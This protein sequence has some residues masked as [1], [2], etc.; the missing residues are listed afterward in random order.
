[1]TS[2][3]YV[4]NETPTSHAQFARHAL[5][6]ARGLRPW[7][8]KTVA[9]WADNSPDFVINLFALW[10]VDAVPL[11]LSR[12]LPWT[13][14]VSLLEAAG[15][16]AVLTHEPGR[17]VPSPVSVL[18][19]ACGRDGEAEESGSEAPA[20]PTIGSK[21]Q[22]VAVILHTSGTTHLPKLVPVTRANLHASLRLEEAHWRGLWTERDAS[23]GWLPLF[24]SYGLVSELLHS[25]RTRSPYY[26]AEPNPHALLRLLER[27]PI[28]R[29]SAVPWMLEQLMALPSG[30]AALARLRWVLHRLTRDLGLDLFVGFSSVASVWG[31]RGLGV[32]TA[33]N[34][35]LDALIHHRRRLGLPGTTVNWGLWEGEGL[36]DEA[37]RQR[38][39]RTGLKPLRAAEAFEALSR[40]LSAGVAQATVARL[41][42]PVFKELQE[43]QRQ[44]PLLTRLEEAPV[45]AAPG[46]AP[47]APQAP[48]W[49]ALPGPERREA[50]SASLRAEAARVL[51]LTAPQ[52]DPGSSLNQLG[53]DSLMALELKR[54][55]QAQGLTVTL[56]VLLESAS[57][58]S[59]TEHLL[60]QLSEGE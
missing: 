25:Y 8:G 34:Q 55:L 10:R 16:S 56:R 43:T 12:R 53:M 49:R 4:F 21:A 27:A 9:L 32:Y 38:L 18:D 2:T 39:E 15:A 41:E 35:F 46:H 13:T 7:K 22:Q 42:V 17:C 1:M 23:L 33:A 36:G 60:A 14:A 6:R 31:G 37:Y 40:L 30:P 3:F 24:H 50:L 51:G 19:A 59:L 5:L 20:L 44:R 45:Q 48:P 28:T 57:V 26:F 47:P 29:L 11:L 58:A 54:G 52:L